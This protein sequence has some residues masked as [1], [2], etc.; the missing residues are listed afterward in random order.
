M[1]EDLERILDQFKTLEEY[2]RIE[3][4]FGQDRRQ[5]LKA[6]L[7]IHSEKVENSVVELIEHYLKNEQ[8][9]MEII[10]TIHWK[11]LL[12]FTTHV[13]QSGEVILLNYESMPL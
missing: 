4:H 12:L 3:K 9:R 5:L 11:R 8:E 6:L 7:T 2:Q 13:Y 10:D 1:E